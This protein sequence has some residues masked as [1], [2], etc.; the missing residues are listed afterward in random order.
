MRRIGLAVVLAFLVAPVAAQTQQAGKVYRI[1]VLREG[2]EIRAKTFA[3]A[4]QE[5]GWIEGQNLKL[6]RRHADR[7]D[8]L[9][10]LA[11]ELVELK[12]DLIYTNGTPAT[13]AAKEATKAIPIVF[14]LGADPVASGLVAS[15]ARPGGNVTGFADGIYDGKLLEVLKEAVPRVSR[16]AFLD[17][18][19]GPSRVDLSAIARALGVEV[20]GISV[21]GPEDFDSFFAAAKRLGDVAVLVPSIAWFRPHLERIGAAAT[22]NRVPSIGP[23]R[24][25]AESGGLLSFGV[26]WPPEAYPRIAAQIDKILAGAKPADL[27]VEQPTKFELVINL[28]TA[29]A[30]GLTIPQSLLVRADEIIR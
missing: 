20:K 15:Y 18:L 3:D 17:T 29:K 30:L 13:R 6:E 19:G 25:F 24:Q 2:A 23:I 9:L 21:N 27:P 14:V 8:K 5:F 10:A 26:A 28:K 1:G 7:Q 4:M 12:V 16:V 11:A 22:R